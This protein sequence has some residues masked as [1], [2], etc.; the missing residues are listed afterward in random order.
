MQAIADAAGTDL[1]TVALQFPF[2]EPVVA[3][4]LLGTTKASSLKRNLDS[5]KVELDP[6][7]FGKFEEFAI[8]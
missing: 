5:M 8:R 2:E 7:I 3:S 6:A 1:A 4:V